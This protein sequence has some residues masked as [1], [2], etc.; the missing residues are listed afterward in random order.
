MHKERWQQHKTSK[1]NSYDTSHVLVTKNFQR[2]ANISVCFVMVLILLLAILALTRGCWGEAP[3]GAAAIKQTIQY[4]SSDGNIGRGLITP[5]MMYRLFNENKRSCV[6]ANSRTERNNET[7][8]L[9][10]NERMLHRGTQSDNGM[11][12][13]NST[14]VVTKLWG[15]SLVTRPVSLLRFE[16]MWHE[17]AMDNTLITHLIKHHLTRDKWTHDL[18]VQENTQ[19]KS[20]ADTQ[21]QQ[22]LAT[23]SI[24]IPQANASI[25]IEVWRTQISTN[26]NHSMGSYPPPHMMP[27]RSF[28]TWSCLCAPTY[29]YIHI[30]VSCSKSMFFFARNVPASQADEHTQNKGVQKWAQ[31][32]GTQRAH[33]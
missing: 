25:N 28:W 29:P 6:T 8:R 22:L 11:K 33:C 31:T 5:D 4:V 30:F 16:K 17:T 15:A 18:T 3:W 27:S 7:Q 20:I 13:K 21:H 23:N 19:Y 32:R 12:P 14:K 26:A 9:T 24:Q 10:Q 1:S 2:N